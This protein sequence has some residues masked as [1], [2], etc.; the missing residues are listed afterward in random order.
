MNRITL[1]SCRF[2]YKFKY[3]ICTRHN[4]FLFKTFFCFRIDYDNITETAK[5]G[6]NHKNVQR[7]RKAFLSVD[8]I[9]HQKPFLVFAVNERFNGR[10]KCK[11]SKTASRKRIYERTLYKRLRTR[12]KRGLPD[13]A[14]THMC[15]ATR[16]KGPSRT[17]RG[18]KMIFQ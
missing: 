7:S 2:V 10:F 18:G 5:I 6:K 1:S 17:S 12:T 13:R 4:N 9:Y 11:K 3:V 8:S 15:T 14:R 16:I